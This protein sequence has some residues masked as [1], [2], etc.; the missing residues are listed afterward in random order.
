M[1]GGAT[2]DER[3]ARV[4]LVN[5]HLRAENAHDLDAIMTTFS[6]QARFNL[7]GLAVSDPGSIRGL[8]DAFGFGGKGSFSN[9]NAEVIQMHVSD[10]AIITELLF[11]GI[12]TDTFQGI[13]AT[14]RQFS[15]PACAIFT[16]D[17]EGK[18]AGE[19]VYF[20]GALVLQQLGV[21]G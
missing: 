15:I 5:E 19:K 16:F 21:L 12:H 18:L 14:N 2:P 20:D 3:A 9:L 8:Y 17:G 11:T 7:N 13:A 10:E 6:Q 4:S 1:S